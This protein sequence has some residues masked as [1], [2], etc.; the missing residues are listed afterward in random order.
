MKLDYPLLAEMEP[1]RDLAPDSGHRHPVYGCIK[2]EELQLFLFG[3]QECTGL[4]EGSFEVVK[5]GGNEAGTVTLIGQ[6]HGFTDAQLASLTADLARLKVWGGEGVFRRRG[7]MSGPS[8]YVGSTA[9]GSDVY[10]GKSAEGL[11]MFFILIQQHNGSVM[12]QGVAIED[13]TFQAVL[14]GVSPSTLTL[15]V[16]KRIKKFEDAEMLI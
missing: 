6:F 1:R 2:G 11:L 3:T 5:M 15:W 4:G 8:T 14:R 10:F 12:A 13:I 9:A 16:D 7:D